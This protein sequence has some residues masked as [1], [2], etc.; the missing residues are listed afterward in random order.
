[1][2]RL[3]GRTKLDGTPC[4]AKAAE[5]P[6]KNCISFGFQVITVTALD[7]GQPFGGYPSPGE[8]QLVLAHRQNGMH[9]R[10]A[11]NLAGFQA[12]LINPVQPGL[13]H[14]ELQQGLELNLPVPTAHFG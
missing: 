10:L 4:A 13:F 6:G 12:K 2:L 1:M 14:A 11:R 3:G 8:N 5:I 9:R 7:G